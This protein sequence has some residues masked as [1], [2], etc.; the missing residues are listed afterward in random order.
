MA[1]WCTSYLGIAWSRKF[2]T[3][4]CTD[5]LMA[6]DTAS[7]FAMAIHLFY[8]PHSY[9]ELLVAKY[10]CKRE[11]SQEAKWRSTEERRPICE[12]ERALDVDLFLGA[13]NQW[14]E[15]SP[16]CLTI[17]HEMF[18]HIASEGWKEVER[19]IC[20]GIW[21]QMPQL[22]PEVDVSAVQLVQPKT[23]Q[24]E[25][26]DIYLEVYKLCRLPSSPPGELAILK[27]V[28]AALPFHSMKEE[29]TP[30]A[31]KQPN[32][33]DLHPPQSRPPRC[34]RESSLD[35]SLA[36]VC[37]AHQKALLATATLEEEIERLYQMR[38]HSGTERRHID[39]DSQESG[40]RR[41]KKMMSSQSLNPACNQQ[42]C[43]SW[44]AS[45]QNGVWRQRLRFGGTTS[46][47]GG[48]SF[49]FARIIQNARR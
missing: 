46:T 8:F 4:S 41:K 49:L 21:W 1:N 32:S 19:Y 44:Y 48:G 13:Q 12:M 11:K 43:Q 33:D 18:L 7:L 6:C 40:E 5:F 17:L 30:G 38:A 27:E 25:L 35:R 23:S 29:D 45:W 34:E 47:Q 39:G 2:H 37:E 31:P 20:Q 16:H 3:L 28:S 36:R 9:H 42:I 22:N 10:G 14:A 24:E 15:D 26:L